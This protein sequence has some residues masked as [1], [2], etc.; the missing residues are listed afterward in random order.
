MIGDE[1]R[2]VARQ[3]LLDHRMAPAVDDE[4]EAVVD[5]GPRVVALGGEMRQGARHVE[6]GQRLGAL[7][8][9]AALRRH[10]RRQPLEDLEL[11]AE[12]ALGGAG[13]LGLQLAE[14]GGG[15]AHLAGQ[16]L[17]VDE[18]CAVRGGGELVAVLRGDLDEIAE[19][20]VVAN[21]QTANA[22]RLGVARLQGGDHAAR[23]VAQAAR[24]V[25]R[26]VVAFAHEAAVAL[27]GG[28]F[29]GERGG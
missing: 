20:V 16:R 27:E 15:E 19:H 28:Q 4:F 9:R 6:R 21:F 14:F 23:F 12:R 29:V 17:P 8:D 5:H 7:L 2:A 22:G 24:L 18:G 13:D 26:R 1:R 25:E 11:D 10:L 3:R